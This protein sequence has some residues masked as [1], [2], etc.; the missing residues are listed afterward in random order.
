MGA[1]PGGPKPAAVGPEKKEKTEYY[2]FH[3][4]FPRIWWCDHGNGASI[5]FQLNSTIR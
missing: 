3:T 5:S 2:L 1:P 4:R